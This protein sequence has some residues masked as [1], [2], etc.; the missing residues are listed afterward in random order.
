MKPASKTPNSAD[1]KIVAIGGGTGIPTLLQGLKK[2][3]KNITAVVTMMDSGGSSGNLRDEFGL[4]PPG[5]VRRA[6]VSLA[7]D[8]RSSLTLRQLFNYRFAKGNGLE[9]HSFGNLFI[10]ALTDIT[11]GTD[12]A[13]AE[14]GR[15][16][17][18]SGR[19]LPVTL[20]NSDLVARLEDGTEIVGE[21][22][23]D[24]RKEKIGVPIDYI[25][26][27]PKAYA[28]SPVIEAIEKADVIVLGPGDLYTSIIPNL[29]VEGVIEAINYSKAKKV[30]ICNL[31]TKMGETDN[32]KAS[33][34]LSEIKSYLDSGK[35]DYFVVN[36]SVFSDRVLKRYE[37]E[38]AS[39]VA[40]DSEKIK[41]LTKNLIT[42]DLAIH[43]N[44][45]RH[46][47]GKTA[48]VVIDI[49]KRN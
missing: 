8:E 5:D 26:L 15:L 4:L 1:P 2:Y 28:Y 42:K 14:A 7:P 44:L 29:L 11:G 20:S 16:L 25:Y 3:T 6:L 34:F 40:V 47:E 45:V 31:M 22:N 13:I 27:D 43:G 33:D 41:K 18:I 36:K 49:A 38:K 30:Y 32:F 35:I 46:D 48:R 39:P 9:G 24:V 21:M 12:K 37:K 17:G 19:V 10:T 23:I